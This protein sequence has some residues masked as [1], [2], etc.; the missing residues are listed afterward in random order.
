[1]ATVTRPIIKL[2]PGKLALLI[3][4]KFDFIC[5]N[6][7]RYRLETCRHLPNTI[8]HAGVSIMNLKLTRFHVLDI[9]I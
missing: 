8:I 4:N 2:E 6:F 9:Y 1:M 7:K 5:T 3:R